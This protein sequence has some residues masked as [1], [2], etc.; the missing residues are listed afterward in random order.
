MAVDIHAVQSP[1]QANLLPAKIRK[2]P[3]VPVRLL[4]PSAN[5]A[6]IKGTD[7]RNKKINQGT[8]KE[9]PPFAPTIL[10]N[11]QIFPVPIAAPIVANISP[12]LPLN[13]S[14]LDSPEACTKHHP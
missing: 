8:R 12:N 13:S 9:P 2:V 11:R 5:S 3:T 14:E 10:G 1:I 7:H 6:M 4:L